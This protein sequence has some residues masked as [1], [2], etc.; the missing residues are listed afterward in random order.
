[1]T[2]NGPMDN[3]A[4]PCQHCWHTDSTYTYTITVWPPMTPRVCCFCGLREL[5]RPPPP[6]IPDGHGPHYPQP[7]RS[8]PVNSTGGTSHYDTCSCNPKNGGS[9]ICGCVLGSSTVTTQ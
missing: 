5:Y 9:G 1:M 4:A 8:Y 3:A 6:P 7:F 2:D